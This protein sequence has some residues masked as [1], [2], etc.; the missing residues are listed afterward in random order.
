M[1][2]VVTVCQGGSCGTHGG[3]RLLDAACVFAAGCDREL[4]DVRT[5]NC[6][7]ECPIGVMIRPSVKIPSYIAQAATAEQ[8]MDSAEAAISATGASIRPEMRQ[9]F[10]LAQEAERLFAEG[11]AADAL[12]AADAALAAVPKDLLEPWHPPLEPESTTWEGTS[13]ESSWQ[14]SIHASP[15][16]LSDSTANFEFGTVS[17][18]RGSLTLCGC[19]VDAD[20]RQLSGEWESSDGSSGSF[21]LTMSE[22]GRFFSGRLEGGGAPE[23]VWEGM[24]L[25]VGTGMRR[26]RRGAPPTLKAAWMH[27]VLLRQSRLLLDSGD[28]DCALQ[29]AQQ[30]VALCCRTATGYALL[31]EVAEACG[32]SEA[33]AAAR[34]DN[35]WLESFA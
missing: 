7:G 29:V 32:D 11:S 31:A 34:R 13:W 1:A 21:L 28:A 20:A 24:R 4:L 25:G 2:S 26:R 18:V 15:L 10:Q 5:A 12:A 17:T 30:V 27:N 3:T 22:D 35:R 14:G 8:A 6:C 23:R 9:V 33:A 19:Q 16:V